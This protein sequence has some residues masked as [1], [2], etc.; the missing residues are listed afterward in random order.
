M[1]NLHITNIKYM[2]FKG[3]ICEI[4]IYYDGCLTNNKIEGKGPFWSYILKYL[5]IKLK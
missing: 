5:K 3:N 1:R 4:C 2:V